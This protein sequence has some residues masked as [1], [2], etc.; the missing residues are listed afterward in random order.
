MKIKA[1][2]GL[3]FFFFGL[4]CLFTAMLLSINT[5]PKIAKSLPENGGLFGPI[6]TTQNNEIYSLAFTQNVPDGQW[7]SIEAEIV[8]KTAGY[9]F[10]ISEELWFE[11]GYDSE[12]RWEE[13]KRDFDMSVTFPTP[14]EYSLNITTSTSRSGVG[15]IYIEANKEIGSMVAFMW[16]GALFSILGVL[17]LYISSK[18]KK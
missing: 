12:G 14:G 6:I 16:M 7:S 15:G 1:N 9:Q 18:S 4:L 2:Y 3:A 5:G 13:G 11:T 17:T 8:E 10:S